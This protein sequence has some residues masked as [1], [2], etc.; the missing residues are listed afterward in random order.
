MQQLHVAL[1]VSISLLLAAPAAAA[2]DAD[3][4]SVVIGNASDLQQQCAAPAT[5]FT[6]KYLIAGVCDL[7]V[8]CV[9]WL[10]RHTQHSCSRPHKTSLTPHTPRP[11]RRRRCTA[12]GE[13]EGGD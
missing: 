6:A 3:D 9:K 11:S 5:A 10:M 1:L 8:L 4:R 7:C 13:C 2:P 12:P